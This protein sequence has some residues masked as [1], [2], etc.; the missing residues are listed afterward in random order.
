MG[1]GTKARAR[2]FVSHAAGISP[3][4]CPS[5]AACS[6]ATSRNRGSIFRRP[7]TARP[8][9]PAVAEA[10]LPP[11]D[12]W[13]GF[14]SR[15]LTEIIEAGARRQS[16]HR[17]GDRA[18]RAGRR[19][20]AH[21][22]R[23]A[24]AE[25]RPQR[26]A[27]RARVPRRRLSGGTGGSAGGLRARQSARRRSTPATRSTSGARTARA[28]RAAE[29]T[30][31]ASRFDREVVGL[32]TV[33]AAANAYFQ[34]LAAQDRLR[35]AQRE[36]RQRDARAQADQAAARRRHRLRSS[37]SRSR[38]AWSTTQRAA[39]P[40]L[41]A[42]AQAEPHRARHSDGA[43]ARTRARARRLAARHRHIRA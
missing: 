17:R 3:R 27:P 38:K 5:A 23:G 14:R 35:V 9:N 12:W 37:T 31:V 18:H 1:W 4:C 10:A 29:E 28:L 41:R 25:R 39:I 26:P 30:A 8:K 36:H 40:P 33:V 16:R 19:A 15:E 13:R 24:V 43:L 34:V 11:L 42:D 32:T 7:M 22:R 6:P 20:G 21:R 2:P